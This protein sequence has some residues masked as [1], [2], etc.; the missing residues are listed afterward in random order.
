MIH[1]ASSPLAI[2]DSDSKAQTAARTR[3]RLSP[4]AGRALEILGHA[5]DYLMDEF[6]RD[7]PEDP[8][9]RQGRV[10]AIQLLMATN[11]GVYYSCPEIPTLADRVAAFFRREAA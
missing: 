9:D 8:M 10:Q 3:R 7:Q 11:R 2:P 1:T 4:E 5:I 6:W